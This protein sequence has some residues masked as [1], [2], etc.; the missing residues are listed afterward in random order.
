M[1]CLGFA[2]SW[3]LRRRPKNATFVLKVP[4]DMRD[5]VGF[6]ISTGIFHDVF[7]VIA[8]LKL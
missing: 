1:R 6:E 2:V 8:D 3:L 5:N 4:M 7:H